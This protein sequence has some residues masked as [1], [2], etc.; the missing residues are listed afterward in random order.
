MTADGQVLMVEMVMPPGN[1]PGVSKAFDVRM[2]VQR[3]A[4][5]GIRTEAEFRQLCAAAGLQLV[6]IIPTAS[7]NSILEAVRV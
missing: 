5:A 7:P 6:R 1:E 2:L 4:G 3:E